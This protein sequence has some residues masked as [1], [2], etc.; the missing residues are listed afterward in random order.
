M[1]KQ[2]IICVDDE[3]T[4]LRSLK[5]ELKKAVG[6]DYL[7]EIAEG[8]TELNLS[9]FPD[10]SLFSRGSEGYFHLVAT[11]RIIAGVLGGVGWKMD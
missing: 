11:G 4:V 7:V 2:V 6:N 3:V 1:T 10:K 8:G 9:L 5:A